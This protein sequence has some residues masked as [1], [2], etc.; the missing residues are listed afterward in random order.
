MRFL[1]YFF[2]ACSFLFCGAQDFSAYEKHYYN[3]P[4]LNLPYR[5]LRPLHQDA[6][7]KYPLVI[8]L[9]GAFERGFDNESQ[10]NIGG[11][12]FLHDSVRNN[13]ASYVLFPQ[14]PESD[15]WAYFE[16]SSD[17]AS[18]KITG[19]TFPFPKKP[20][21]VSS[22]LKKL[23]DSLMQ[24]DAIDPRRIYIAGL[25]QG[26]MGV[27][28][29]LARYPDLFAAG[30]SICG[31]GNAG[32]ARNFA[33]SSALWLF[34]GSDDDVIPVSFSQ[35]YYKKLKKLSADVRYSEYPGVKHNSW[36]NAFTDPEF[37]RW[38]FSKNK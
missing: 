10:L 1:F 14:C 32:T 36:V 33:H 31:A 18:G 22:A 35:A 38:L 12:F 4:E 19:I 30:I 37:L 25:S 9:H 26:A 2:S 23:I 21:D 17:A 13:Y 24:R 28:D 16:T 15:L 11:R 20:T 34:H 8:F 7:K 6:D 5:L 27:L 29:F 3:A